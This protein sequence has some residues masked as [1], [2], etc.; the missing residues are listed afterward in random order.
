MLGGVDAFGRKTGLELPKFGQPL[1]SRLAA[2]ADGQHGV[3]TLSQLRTLGLTDSAVRKRAQAGRLHRVHAG[4]YAVG[5]ARLDARG[6]RMGAVLACG[7]GAVL[8][9]RTAGDALGIAPRASAAIEIAIPSRSGRGRPGISVHRV[10]DLRP[11]DVTTVDGIPCTT[12]ARTLFDLAAV[13]DATRLA[14]AIENTERLGLFDKSEL[15]GV[16]ERAHGRPAATRLRAA[17]A[18]YVD[19]P[20]PPTRKELERRAFEVFAQAGL[21]KPAV[22]VLVD[23]AAGQL[24][25]DFC[26]PERR[27]IVEMDSFEFH[28]TRAAF[29]RDRRRDLLLRAAGWTSLRIT[30]RQLSGR[31]AEVIAAVR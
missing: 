27:L 2:L 28:G 4:V 14:N 26:W 12:P 18:A 7:P 21:P 11:E 30:W 10:P 13:V 5:R 25:V 23:T 8:F 24:E 31:P 3:V 6:R 16:I 15:E 22:N 17:L 9:R 1:D 29:E 20:P 19:A